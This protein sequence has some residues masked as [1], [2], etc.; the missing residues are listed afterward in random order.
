VRELYDAGIEPRLFG[1]HQTFPTIH[2]RLESSG[3]AGPLTH[4]NP[5][6]NRHYLVQSRNA[7]HKG[8]TMQGPA[9]E[10]EKVRSP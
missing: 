9:P 2:L 5:S 10:P 4:A 3:L 6:Y 8:G 7:R 1:R